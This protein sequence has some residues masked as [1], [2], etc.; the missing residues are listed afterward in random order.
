MDPIQTS[1]ILK[2]PLACVRKPPFV[3]LYTCVSQWARLQVCALLNKEQ[4]ELLLQVTLDW[5]RSTLASEQL[6][7]QLPKHLCG[8]GL[9]RAGG[10][11]R[12]FINA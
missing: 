2:Q 3:P 12:L 10:I 6:S 8:A 5:W 4:R 11:Q 7:L 1:N 9:C